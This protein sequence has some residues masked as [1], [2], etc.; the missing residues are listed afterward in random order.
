MVNAQKWLESQEEYNT[1]AKKSEIKKLDIS[2]KNLESRL[3]LAEFINLEELNCSSN[4]LIELKIT[5]CPNLKKLYCSDNFL[6]S[7]DL[8]QNEELEEL[9]ITSNNFSEQN[10]SFLTHLINLKRLELRNYNSE[11]IEKN[12]YNR[13]VGSLEFLKNL[14]NLEDLWI[15]DTDIENG[16]EYL[17]DSLKSFQCSTKNRPE[18]KARNIHEEL[19]LYGGNL[20]AWKEAHPELMTIEKEN[21]YLNITLLTV[22]P[23]QLTEEKNKL[24]ENYNLEGINYQ[25]ITLRDKRLFSWETGKV[26]FLFSNELPIKLYNIKTKQ[27]EETQGRDD[28]KN[29]AT[30]S[31]VWGDMK[32]SEKKK[33]IY[34]KAN[35][36]IEEKEVIITKWGIKTLEKAIKT[37]K[38]LGI[39]YLWM[40]QLCI[41]QNNLEEKNQEVPKMRQYYNNSE[42]NLISINA[43][44]HNKT[45]KEKNRRQF[46]EEVLK[47]IVNSEW[48][49]RSWTFQEGL[50]SRQTIFMFDNCLMD[51][52]ILA[53]VWGLFHSNIID[54]WYAGEYYYRKINEEPQ[55]F[56]TPLG[57]TYCNN[58]VEAKANLGLSQALAGIKNRKRIIP[59]D[60]IYSILGLLP[61]GSKVTPK[62]KN[63]GEV[64]TQKELEETLLDIMKISLQSGNGSEVLSW[65][66]SRRSE[67]NK[68]WIPQ[69]DNNGSANITG[70]IAIYEPKNVKITENGVVLDGYKYTV[71]HLRNEGKISPIDKNIGEIWIGTN[72]DNFFGFQG[73]T[74]TLKKIKKGDTLVIP[75]EEK[76]KSDKEFAFLVPGENNLC[77]QVNVVDLI[78]GHV[79]KGMN[80]KELIIDMVNRKVMEMTEKITTYEANIEVSPK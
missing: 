75:D 2:N 14:T 30:L 25:E 48:F 57:W 34:K 27:V 63:W 46:I 37:C 4:Q 9:Q 80:S 66:G 8:S 5:N 73:F 78:S 3:D 23:D 19:F 60:G 71:D 62:Y 21:K 45:A 61:Y 43:I 77:Y 67:I 51:G 18:A 56:V 17:P 32:E 55:I 24:E 74:E 40:D 10:L 39:D 44:S 65:M 12:I 36:E 38:L 69:I 29:Y 31:Y 58:K 50:L 22:I 15:D 52:R 54:Y 76:L 70:G 41:D 72:G 35:G 47:K 79:K 68:W 53:Q 16:L 42:V 6:T 26:K 7:L 64:Y 20:K 28:I 59:I 11:K 1:K 13:F 33:Q 49:S